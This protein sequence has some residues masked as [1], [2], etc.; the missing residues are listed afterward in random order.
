LHGGREVFDLATWLPRA[1]GAIERLDLIVFV[2]VEARDRIV[3][4]RSEKAPFRRPVDAKLREILMD[5]PWGFDV[6]VLEVAG[7]PSER[8][9]QVVTH[10]RVGG[11][12][13]R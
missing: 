6:D 8:A 10:L 11:P 3:L 5:D 4:P 7:T 1:Q 9:R 13:D 12:D 2:A